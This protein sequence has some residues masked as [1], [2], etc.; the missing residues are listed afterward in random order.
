MAVEHVNVL[1]MGAGLSGIDA[2][3][4]LQK[5]C[6]D[7][8]YVILEQRDRIGGT[9][10]LFRYPGIRSDSDVL[11]MGY[12]FRPWTLPHTI[13]PGAD[14]RDYIENTARNEGIDRHIRFRHR[15]RRASWSSQDARWTVEAFRSVAE[16]RTE[17]PVAFTANFLFSCAG[18]YRYSAGYAPE[19]PGSDRFQG[20]IVHPQAWPDDLDYSGKSVV[21]VGSGAT[22]VTLL[23]A[24]AKTAGHVTMLQRSPTYFISMPGQDPI[25]KALRRVMPAA[26]AYRL[27]R[28]KNILL[29]MC[30]YQYAQ[31]FPEAAKKGLIDRVRK[32]LGPDYDVDKHFTPRYY[33]WDQRLCLVPDSDFFRAIKEGCASVVTDQIETFT[34]RG[35]RLASGQELEADV[36]VTATGLVMQTFGGAELRVDGRAVDAGKTLAYRGVMMSGVPN[37]AAVFGYVNA[38]WTLKADLI[39]NYVC[40][41]LNQMDRSGMRQATPK[42][43]DDAPAATFV[44]KFTPG[45]IQRALESW[46]KQGSKAPWRV[47]Q[48]YFRD[49]AALKWSPVANKHLELS[50]PAPA[51]ASAGQEQLAHSAK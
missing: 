46:P 47:N 15:I 45:Y 29:T 42:C 25:A 14:I 26:W 37:F 50:N 51:I 33:P 30:I 43:L 3:H 31:R 18:Y 39:C 23:P 16:G 38:S 35:I 19:F 44:E 32:E 7:K 48:N 36:I 17:E 10:D 34:E 1:I 49:V 41:L 22:A 13:S 20:R 27:S 5:L 4:H 6:P 40:R 12:S 8:T 9:W 21:I 28:W 2:A 24:M 11:T